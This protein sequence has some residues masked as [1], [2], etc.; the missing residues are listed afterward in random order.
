MQPAATADLARSG[1]SEQDAATCGLFDVEDA[2]TVYPDFEPGP[3]LVIPYY[4]PTGELMTFQRGNEALPFCRIRHMDPKNAGSGF[5]KPKPRRYSQPKDSGT[6]AYFC[7]LIDWPRVL[8]DPKI[9]IIITEGEKKAI[10][11]CALGYPVIGLGGVFNFTNGGEELMPELAAA[12]WRARKF[13]MCFDSDAATNPNILTAESR[14]VDELQRKRGA[15]GFLLRLPPDGDKKV[16]LDDFLLT[17]GPEAFD[18]LVE[19][20]PFLGALDAKVVSLNQHVAWIEKDGMVWDLEECDWIKKDNFMNGSRYSALTHIGVGGKQRS[21]PK[22]ISVAAEWLRHP[23]AQRY[24]QLL[25][26]P[27]GDRVVRSEQGTPALNMWTGWQGQE[28]GDVKPF[29]D[30]TEFLFQNLPAAHRDLPL[31]LMAYKAQNP[32]EKFALALV[33]LGPQGCG[34]TMWGDILRR[35]MAPYSTVVNPAAFKGVFQGWMEKSLLVVVN[36]AKGQDIEEASEELKSLISD[37]R[38]DMN[39]KFRPAR[40][41]STYFQFIITS[42]KR[43]VGSFSQDD[44]RM[45]VVDCPKP[46]EESFYLDYLVPW[47]D[48]GGPKWLLD[49]LLNLDLKGWRPPAHAPMTAEK[50]LAY[51]ESLTAVQQIANEMR[52][53]GE[54]TLM[55]WLDQAVAWAQAALLNNNTMLHGAAN[56]TLEG[57]KAL[58]IRPWYEPRELAMIFPNLVASQLGTRYDK[59]TPPGQLSRQLRDAGVPYLVCKDDPRGFFWHGQFRQFLVVADFDEWGEALSQAD[60]ERLM[61]HWPTYAQLRQPKGRVA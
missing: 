54:H 9:P 4:H 8:A 39:E 3:A 19:S 41:I 27:G 22:K 59:N 25:F 50:H 44:R 31:K 11:G 33:L 53:G 16:G 37:E 58:Q 42:N 18:G 29:L 24:G 34:K 35:A 55:L 43:A 7:P 30:L 17:Y 61:Q 46:R 6:R 14:L 12:E 15:Q 45:I 57:I 2:S 51:T 20:A 47:R 21:D 49:Y 36:E 52:S 48:A 13:Y 38:R 40:Q 5:S 23:H 56:A 60:F 28:P 10:A 1:I 32:Q 26:R